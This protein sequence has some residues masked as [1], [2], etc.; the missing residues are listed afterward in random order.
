MIQLFNEI[1]IETIGNCNRACP[2]CLRQSYP[3]RSAVI[4]RFTGFRWMPTWLYHRIIDQAEAMGY[5]GRIN[6]QFFNEP[7]MDRRLPY[8]ARYARGKGFGIVR[9]FS[10]ADILT[11]KRAAELDG[12]LD[13]IDIAL[14]AP[15]AGGEPLI[16]GRAEREALIRSWF[17]RTH[18]IFTGGDHVVTHFSP[19]PDLAARIEQ[20]RPMP[21][22][23]DAQERLIVDH[24]GRMLMCCDDIADEFDLGNLTESTLSDLWFSPRHVALVQALATAGGRQ[25]HPYCWSCPR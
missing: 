7:L 3:D 18:V 8:F 17:S 19:R 10:N 12:L 22:I 9:G 2:T 15:G 23:Y 25:V 13:E 14:Y 4:D 11:E 20:A 6:L 16:E 24:N 5:G 1:T 21:C